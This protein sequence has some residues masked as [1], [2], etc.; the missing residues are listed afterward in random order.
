M[1]QSSPKIRESCRTIWSRAITHADTNSTVEAV[2]VPAGA[3]VIPFGVT[4][5]VAELL[6]GGTPKLNVGDGTTADGFVDED[7]I[8]ATTV[9]CYTGTSGNAAYSDTGRFYATTDTIDV[10]VSAGLT[11]GT[12]YIC[13][14]YWDLSSCDLTAST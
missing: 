6:D 5:Y 9:G 4:V 14:R 11:D 2:V 8:T 1:A 3:F 10:A 7:D 12:A 13:V